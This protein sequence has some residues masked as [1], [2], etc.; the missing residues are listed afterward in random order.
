MLHPNESAAEKERR[1]KDRQR[2]LERKNAEK[3][4]KMREAERLERKKAMEKAALMMDEAKSNYY[5]VM[6]IID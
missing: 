4:R 1:L 6:R 3:R 2:R 5:A